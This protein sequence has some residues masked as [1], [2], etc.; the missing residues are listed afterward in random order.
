MTQKARVREE[1]RSN[2]GSGGAR[3][4]LVCLDLVLVL[5]SAAF[6]SDSCFV[7][8]DCER[9]SFTLQ[10]IDVVIVLVV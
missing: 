5:V 10:P 8:S 3:A 2:S 4:G 9:L 7:P 6:L 1:E